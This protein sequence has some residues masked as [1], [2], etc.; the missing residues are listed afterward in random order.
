MFI[1]PIVF[2]GVFALGMLPAVVCFTFAMIIAK[3]RTHGGLTFCRLGR[4]GFS[5]YIRRS[6]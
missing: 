3:G 1:D 4:L 2:Y 5:F 6:A